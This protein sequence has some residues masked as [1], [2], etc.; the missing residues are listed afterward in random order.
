MDGPAE[1][2]GGDC[3]ADDPRFGGV[4]RLFGDAGHARI[5][6]AR[7]L[8]VGVGG[9]GSWAAEC[10]ARNGI[11]GITMVDLDD[12]CLTNVNRQLHAHDGTIGRLKVEAMVERV[13]AIHPSC[14][15]AGVAEFFNERTAA[16]ILGG[17]YDAVID[18]ID[19]LRHKALLVAESHS[20]GIP[21][22][23]CGAAGGRRDASRIQTGDLA[24]AGGDPLL[25][26]LRRRLRREHGFAAVPMGRRP[27][28][29]GIEA[30]FSAEPRVLPGGCGPAAGGGPTLGCE[31]GYGSVAQVT[32][33]FGMMAAGVVI[34]RLVEAADRG[35]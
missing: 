28:A 29:M 8:V 27:E 35:G 4:A 33:C 13:R 17:G 24:H 32:A 16:G 1:S 7:V 14:A 6:A 18:A 30:V 22:V 23:V 11:G 9:V 26:S 12:I 10:L 19:T 20:R 21:V 15:V 2:V 5:G 25:H 31:T 34:N 3:D